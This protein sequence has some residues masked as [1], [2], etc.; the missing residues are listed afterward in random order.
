MSNDEI[1]GL[2]EHPPGSKSAPARIQAVCPA[3]A[4]NANCRAIATQDLGRP[5]TYLS[6]L[7]SPAL[8]N[9]RIGVRDRRTTTKAQMR[10]AAANGFDLEEN[11]LCA[12][13]NG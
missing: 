5:I 11:Y 9:F 3:A 10:R 7:V 12:N 2:L 8:Q 1:L 4:K 13:G 6:F